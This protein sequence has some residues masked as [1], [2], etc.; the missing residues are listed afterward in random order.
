MRTEGLATASEQRALP[1][2]LAG[3]SGSLLRAHLAV[4][5]VDV[6]A[7]LGGCGALPGVVALVDNGEV[8]E[9]A[10]EGEVEVL[11]GPL[12]K[13]LRLERRE[14]VDGDGDG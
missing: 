12:L 6:V 8:E 9:I 7:G 1:G 3:S 5:A 13:G 11:D 4:R 14:A 2:T 10:A